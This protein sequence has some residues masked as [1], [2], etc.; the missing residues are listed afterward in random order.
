M[1]KLSLEKVTQFAFVFFIPIYMTN[2][3]FFMRGINVNMFMYFPALALLLL[4]IFTLI[5]KSDRSSFIHGINLYFLYLVISVFLYLVNDA[6][7]SCYT[8]MFTSYLLPFSFVFLG[9]R[10]SND[11]K[12]NKWYLYGCAIC[13]LI[14]FYLYFTAPSYYYDFLRNNVD[15]SSELSAYMGSKNIDI[16]DVTRFSSFFGNSYVISYFSIPA[17]ILSLGYTLRD[18]SGIK[19]TLLY[20]I[21]VVSILAAILCQQRIAMAFAVIIPFFYGIYSLRSGKG[22][23]LL[24]I[25]LIFAIIFVSSLFFISTLPRFDVVYELIKEQSSRMIFSDAMAERVNQYSEFN[26]STWWSFFVG[27]GFGA[28]SPQALRSGLAGIADG[29]FVK[30]FYEIGIIGTAFFVAIVYAT[31]K[32][33]IKNFKLYNMEVLIILFFLAAGIAS[34]SLTMNIPCAMFWFSIGRIWNKEYSV[35]IQLD[36]KITNYIK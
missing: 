1:K 24:Q 23:R 35:I 7:I 25:S 4:K 18:D 11:N 13:F 8:G 15:E 3:Y 21:A 2:Y 29:E 27:L 30:M 16:L 36:N 28:C 26:R 32:K 22:G 10:Y 19:K 33:G 31:L 20:F 14:G 17:L 5:L 34:D 6:P 9:Y 12:Y